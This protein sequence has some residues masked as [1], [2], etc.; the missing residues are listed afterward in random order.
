MTITASFKIQKSGFRLDL[1]LDLPG[2]GITGIFG[3]SGSGKTTLLRTIAGLEKHPGRLKISEQIWQDKNTFLPAH[4]R[5]IG[6]V[7][8]EPQLFPHLNVQQNLE[9]GQRRIPKKDQK[10]SLE[11]SIELLDIANILHRSGS[12]L[13]GGEKQR[14][15][16]ARAL[17]VSPQLLL[18]DEPLASLDNRLKQEILPYIQALHRELDI[19]MLY[20]SH[21][22]DEIAQLADYL[23]LVR[24]E[25]VLESGP[26]DEMLTRLDL[27]LAQRRGAESILHTTVDRVESEYGLTKVR[28]GEESFQVT[29][30]AFKPGQKVRLRIAAQDVSIC[31]S[32]SEHS[33]ILNIVPVII[34]AIQPQDS[35]QVMIKLSLGQQKILARVTKKSVDVLQL[36]PDQLVYA[37]IKSVA[38]LD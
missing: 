33:S 37:Q 16:I 8:Q 35:A 7:F 18:M 31:L 12:D 36:A 23:V 13:S 11:Q 25:K 28:C 34:D 15:G 32:K 3:P 19:P 2:D 29:G 26:L 27:P 38:V 24:D 4:K 1:S 9:Y 10:I 17:A 14:V 5:S 20:V 21:S 22:M 6:F 30:A